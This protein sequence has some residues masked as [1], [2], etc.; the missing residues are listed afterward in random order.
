MS[1][2]HV[3]DIRRYLDEG[4]GDDARGTFAVW[5]GVGE[6]SRFA[7]PLWRVIYLLGGNW[8]GIVSLAK[9]GVSGEGENTDGP[10]ALLILDLKEDPARTRAPSETLNVLGSE[11]APALAST[12]AGGLAVL[13]GEDETRMWFLQV[14]GEEMLTKPEGKDLETLLFLAGECSGLLFL[15]DL[16]TSLSQ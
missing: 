12:R 1:D 8:G 11:S 3:I 6:G 9:N 2:D 10:S 7:L 4:L 16:S 13:L 5:G 14:L 15:R